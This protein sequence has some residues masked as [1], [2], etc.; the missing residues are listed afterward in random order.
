LGR[1]GGEEFA[2]LFEASSLAQAEQMVDNIRQLIEDS[3]V[4]LEHGERIQC[5]I[6]VGLTQKSD[7]INTIDRMLQSADKALYGAKN[8][9]RNRLIVRSRL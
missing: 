2:M 6:S 5:T 7:V 8:E 1:I 4:E 3:H 9:G